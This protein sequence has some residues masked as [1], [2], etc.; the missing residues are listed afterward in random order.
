MSI[1]A[2][3]LPLA[4]VIDFSLMWYKYVMRMIRWIYFVNMLFRFCTLCLLSS[5]I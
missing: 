3:G 1:R 4:L 2:F 5:I